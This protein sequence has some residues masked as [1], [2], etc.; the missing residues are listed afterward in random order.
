MDPVGSLIPDKFIT[1]GSGAPLAMGLIEA[2]YSDELDLEAGGELALNAIRSA[3]ARDVV[4]GD[5]VDMLLIKAEGI[6][7]RSYPMKA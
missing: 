6:E 1:A 4:S 3:V 7:E 5:G 2:Q